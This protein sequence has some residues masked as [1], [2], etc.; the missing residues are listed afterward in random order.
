MNEAKLTLLCVLSLQ[1][2]FACGTSESDPI[3]A[4]RGAGAAGIG[5]SAAGS[6]G[7]ASTGGTG[8]TAGIGGKGGTG[9]ST[10]GS[11]ASGGTSNGGTGGNGASAGRGT[12]TGGS[13]GD[14]SA[15]EAGASTGGVSG[16]G[17]NGN[18]GAAGTAG[19]DC[20]PV[21]PNVNGPERTCNFGRCYCPDS[22]A[23][24]T[25][26]TA[27]ACCAEPVDCDGAMDPL[28]TINHPG[29]G[30]MRAAGS[31]IPFAGLATD[32]QDGSLTG[33]ALV[34]TSSE[35]TDPIGTGASF[36]ATLPAGTHVVTLTAT[37]SDSNTGTDTITLI[38]E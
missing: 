27:S 20:D 24:F 11:S 12:T 6:A 8:G 21:H 4:P 10:G 18:A 16:G 13:A 32:P 14:A 30:E 28:V 34:W 31:S 22:D 1:G 5:G 23:C 25:E 26:A 15:G 9:G 36:D 17:G 3:F 38:V 29:D 2:I 33:E 37:D 19:T 7:K 35:L